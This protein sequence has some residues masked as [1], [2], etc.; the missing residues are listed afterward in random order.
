MIQGIYVKKASDVNPAWGDGG[1]ALAMA[2]APIATVPQTVTAV[3]SAGGDL[4]DDTYYYKVTA[5][6]VNGETIGSS[7]VNATTSGTD[8]SV[9]LGW[10]DQDDVTFRVYRGLATGVYTVC[11]EVSTNALIDDGSGWVTCNPIPTTAPDITAYSWSVLGNITS[12][13]PIYIPAGDDGIGTTPKRTV[14][15]VFYNDGSD[16]V[17]INL[18]KVLNQSGWNIG[19]QAAIEQAVSDILSW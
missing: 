8:N 2:I 4:D 19:T 7:E 1:R 17:N 13:V 16:S 6:G 3:K 11:Q 10:V 12:V 5:I 18:Q 15:T 9:T 14:V